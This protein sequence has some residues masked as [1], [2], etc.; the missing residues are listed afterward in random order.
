MFPQGL[1]GGPGLRACQC[2]TVPLGRSRQPEPAFV[3]GVTGRLLGEPAAVG[4]GLV[5]RDANHRV[6]GLVALRV[7]P[8]QGSLD[9]LG[10]APLPAALVPEFPALV[11]TVGEEAGE[12]QVRDGVL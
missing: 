7:A 4:D 9:A 10:L 11:A 2:Y 1:Q 5:N 3:A 12:F 6:V 8:V